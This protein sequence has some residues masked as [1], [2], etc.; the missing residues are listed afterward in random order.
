LE[1]PKEVIQELK[2]QI[3]VKDLQLEKLKE[4]IDRQRSKLI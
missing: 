2:Q 3:M 4:V 1:K